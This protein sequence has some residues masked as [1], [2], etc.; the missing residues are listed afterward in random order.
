MA[1]LKQWYMQARSD[2]LRVNFPVR[3]PP[4]GLDNRATLALSGHYDNRRLPWR[5]IQS[6]V[7][8]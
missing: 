4:H 5:S 2:T 7:N 1:R 6:A 3:R 8:H